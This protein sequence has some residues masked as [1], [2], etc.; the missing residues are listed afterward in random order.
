MNYFNNDN[1]NNNIEYIDKLS[2]D[3]TIRKQDIEHQIEELEDMFVLLFFINTGF[4]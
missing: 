3:I 1:N 2:K 4:V